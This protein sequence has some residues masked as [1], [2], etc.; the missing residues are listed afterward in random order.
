VDKK[1]KK[2][3]PFEEDVDIEFEY[4]VFLI[5][6]K[7]SR[8]KYFIIGFIAILIAGTILF[9]V[10][11]QNQE[12][13]YNQASKL[14]YQIKKAYEDDDMKKVKELMN[15]DIEYNPIISISDKA[16][17]HLFRDVKKG[18]GT[19]ISE[20]LL[21]KIPDILDKPDAILI[22]IQDRKGVPTLLYIKSTK[23]KKAKFV[24][25]LSR[26]VQIVKEGKRKKIE[27]NLLTTAGLVDITNLKSQR[28]I[29]LKGE[30]E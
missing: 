8:Y 17:L 30:L 11:K 10:Y 23:D 13:F 19:A 1:E 28:Y 12:E 7:I 24:V 15:Y 9:F 20:D 25:K 29:L 27:V 14:V 16:I 2:S 18:R 3:L 21:L 4:K 26:T 22:D 5:L 6:D